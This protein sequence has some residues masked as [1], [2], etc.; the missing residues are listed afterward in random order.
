VLQ[1][2][3]ST[4]VG[5]RFETGE[6]DLSTAQHVDDGRIKLAVDQHQDLAIWS[7]PQ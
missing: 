2:G 7:C 3:E 1:Q 6:I 5:V 4:S